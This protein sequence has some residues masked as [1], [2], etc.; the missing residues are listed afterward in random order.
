MKLPLLATCLLMTL[1][2]GA[3]AG[4]ESI[5]IF[6]LKPGM[7]VEEALETPILKG[8]PLGGT[9]VTQSL[10]I[11]WKLEVPPEKFLEFLATNHPTVEKGELQIHSQG[12]EIMINMPEPLPTLLGVPVTR[13][14]LF[15][16]YSIKRHAWVITEVAVFWKQPE[17]KVDDSQLFADIR[18]IITKQVG[19]K[20]DG[21]KWLGQYKWDI[22]ETGYLMHLSS[23]QMR[24][25]HHK[26]ASALQDEFGDAQR[27]Q[28]ES[29]PTYKATGTLQ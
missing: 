9:G 28:I 12:G 16:I 24:I 3:L 13:I 25:K 10:N 26:L 6:G 21:D 18:E 17:I 5:T 7:T 19:Y 1:T 27:K 4:F 20:S 2:S 29:N 11:H 15:G 23:S 8:K 22:T 14:S